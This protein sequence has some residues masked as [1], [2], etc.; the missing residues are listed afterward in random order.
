MLAELGE[1]QHVLGEPEAKLMKMAEGT[2]KVA[3]NVQTAVDTEHKLVVHHEVT[4]DMSD[5]RRLLP[6]AQAVKRAL[7]EKPLNVVADAG[8]SNGEHAKG[9]EEAGITAYVPV[10]RSKNTQDEGMYFDRSAFQYDKASE[11]YRCPAGEVRIA[12]RDVPGVRPAAG[13]R[14]R[15]A[16]ARSAGHR[17][18]RHPRAGIRNLPPVQ[19]AVVRQHG[20][21]QG[22]QRRFRGA[23]QFGR[24]SDA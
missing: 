6:M 10:Q 4:S 12:R 2:S 7:G 5:Q 19:A 21:L 3:Y 1:K 24:K 9:C 17:L 13:G 22:A 8:Y 16:H 14:L 11:S 15:A 20:P 23:P 18:S